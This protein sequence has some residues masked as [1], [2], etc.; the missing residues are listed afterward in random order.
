MIQCKHMSIKPILEIGMKIEKHNIYEQN[1]HF[2]TRLLPGLLIY[3][4]TRTSE[5]MTSL[6]LDGPWSTKR[7]KKYKYATKVGKKAY[8]NENYR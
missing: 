5:R 3:M 2:Q 1:Q 8:K 7:I 6:S 4:G